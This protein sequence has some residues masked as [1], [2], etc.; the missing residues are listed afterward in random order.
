MTCHQVTVS[1]CVRRYVKKQDAK[2]SQQSFQAYARE[3]RYEAMFHNM[4]SGMGCNERLP[5]GQTA[6]DQ[7]ETVLMWMLR[8]SGTGGLSG[9][10]PKRGTRI[11]RPLLDIPRSDILV[12]LHEQQL[13]YRMDSSNTQ[14]LYLRNKIR[15]TWFLD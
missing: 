5:L 2:S 1:I 14:P 15:K 9:I 3:A 11:V 6:D 4:A 10:P 8:G 13:A 12:Y 7:A